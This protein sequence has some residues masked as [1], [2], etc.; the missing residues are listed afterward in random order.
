MPGAA[1][2]YVCFSVIERRVASADTESMGQVMCRLANLYQKP[3]ITSTQ[4]TTAEGRL[5]LQRIGR[6]YSKAS[7]R[8]ESGG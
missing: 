1:C 6:T 2:M 7:T 5:L 4:G 8:L 3:S